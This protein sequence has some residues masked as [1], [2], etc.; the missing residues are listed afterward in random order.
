MESILC[1]QFMALLCRVVTKLLEKATL[2]Q[3]QINT[4]RLKRCFA[5]TP[6]GNVKNASCTCGF[7]NC[8]RRQ[9]VHPNTCRINY[10]FISLSVCPFPS[11]F[12]KRLCR[13][14]CVTNHLAF[15][16]RWRQ[17]ES[18][19]GHLAAYRVRRSSLF[20]LPQGVFRGC[21]ESKTWQQRAFCKHEND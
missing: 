14:F 20:G 15:Q 3:N 9:M 8:R 2:H 16:V 12:P 18:D 10:L 1:L 11:R 19:L 13:C 17:K 5:P 6:T 21:V 4:E 7:L